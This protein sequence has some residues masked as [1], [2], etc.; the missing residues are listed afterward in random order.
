MTSSA[1]SFAAPDGTALQGLRWDTAN[2]RAL[3]YLV[4]G[5]AEH[6]ERYDAFAAA[7]NAAGFSVAGHDQRGHGRT[8]AQDNSLGHFADHEGWTRMVD[9]AR[10]GVTAW[11]TTQPGLPMILFGHSMGS[12]IVQQALWSWPELMDGAVLSG[13]NGPPPPLAAIGRVIARVEQLRL[14]RRGRS[15]LIHG[16][17]FDGM[18]K[19]FQPAR[20]DMDWLSRDAEMVDRYINDP[21][22]GFIASTASW[23]SLLDALSGLA[24]GSNVQ[25]IPKAMPIH[26]AAGARDPVGDFGKGVQRLHGIYTGAGLT[27]VTLRLYDDAR[28]EILNEINREEVT[29]DLIGR[30]DAML[31]TRET[32]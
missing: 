4:H 2:P 16:L 18:N 14:G 12:F 15:K 10:C 24:S 20:T 6:I 17:G 9:D 31:E 28:H 30:M 13:S 27:D 23:I 1:W 21:D 11:R 19:T 26:L 32:T 22:C 7:L 8:A 29:M 3:V 25:R 5:L